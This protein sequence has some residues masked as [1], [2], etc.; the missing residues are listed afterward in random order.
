[1]KKD[2][3]RFLPAAL[4]V[5]AFATMLI[6][7]SRYWPPLNAKSQTATCAVHRVALT[8]GLVRVSRYASPQSTNAPWANLNYCP[9]SASIWKRLADVS[10]CPECRT[11][12]PPGSTGFR[13]IL[14]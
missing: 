12:E 9:P 4:S 2:R 11:W 10:Y 5:A 14:N 13:A 8:N 1:M 6:Q 3:L 7:G